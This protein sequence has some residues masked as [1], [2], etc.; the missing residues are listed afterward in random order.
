VLAV[1][2]LTAASTPVRTHLTNTN[3][4]GEQIL[5]LR[6]ACSIGA[7][8]GSSVRR[9]AGPLESRALLTRHG[10]LGGAVPSALG[11]AADR[12]AE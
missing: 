4:W 2:P 1:V 6:R 12:R 3:V 9:L 11:A 7:S 10:H 5:L 8:S